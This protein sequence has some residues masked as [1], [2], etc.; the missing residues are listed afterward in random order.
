[1]RLVEEL[2]PKRTFRVAR[3]ECVS[4]RPASSGGE[5][6]RLALEQLVLRL[7]EAVPDARS[8]LSEILETR[9]ADTCLASTLASSLIPDASLRQRLLEERDPS[10]R[11]EAIEAAIAELLL[12][13]DAGGPAHPN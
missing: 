3:V 6:R 5:A 4:D 8:A 13:L 9:A 11:F 2:P 10:A 7:I 1:V 12:R